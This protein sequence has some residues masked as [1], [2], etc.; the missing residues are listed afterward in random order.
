M[1]TQEV[2]KTG[3]QGKLATTHEL[4]QSFIEACQINYKVGPYVTL[5]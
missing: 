1:S 5:H 3:E 2:H 4:W